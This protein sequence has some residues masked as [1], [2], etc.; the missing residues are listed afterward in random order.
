MKHSSTA[1]GAQIIFVYDDVE[2]LSWTR[3]LEGAH[4]QVSA[5]RGC[6]A[7]IQQIENGLQAD[8]VL[9][10]L[11]APSLDDLRTIQ[12]C[13][14]IRA[15]LKIVVISTV[16]DLSAVVQAMRWGA[17]DYI[18]RPQDGSE[19]LAEVQR[20]LAASSNGSVDPELLSNHLN[21]LKK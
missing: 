16:I 15:E 11:S 8:L 5:S 13:L 10:N 18:S 19:L 9:L 20:L 6:E 2:I 1:G 14:R 21:S 12:V 3:L 17:L 4:Y 7:A